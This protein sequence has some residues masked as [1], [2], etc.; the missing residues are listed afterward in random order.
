MMMAID[1]RFV[2]G[3]ELAET[4]RWV[5][6]FY[7][8]KASGEF[9]INDRQLRYFAKVVE[10][11]NMTKAAAALN[12]AQPALGLQIRQ[13]EESLGV[14]LLDRHSRGVEVTH[15]GRQLYE[16]ACN[17]LRLMEETRLEL[18][19]FGKVGRE[20]LVLGV[21]P[22]I[23][24]LVGPQFLAL[25]RSIMPN[26]SVSLVEEPSF[27]LAEGLSRDEIDL[28][29]AYDVTDR[30]G[31]STS[32]LAIEELL[33][34]CHPDAAPGHPVISLES[35]ISF[36]LV[37][38]HQRDPIRQTVE[39]AAALHNLPVRVMFEMQS[40]QATVDLVRTGQ[41]ATIVP[42][43]TVAN[44]VRRGELASR[45]I[46]NRALERH[47]QL[48]RPVRRGRFGNEQAI[49]NFIDAVLEELKRELGTL[50]RPAAG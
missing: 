47:L 41:A 24:R 43:G 37:L 18:R 6:V 38:V 3:H 45:R 1:A 23:M 22:S 11:G 36:D 8:R 10:S 26:V 9:P 17:I 31:V 32:T 44:E 5:I 40:L 48:A 14:A 33:F 20:T 7:P 42:F 25:A 29:L 49:L 34:V 27:L 15:A 21:A 35:A 12:I 39:Q 46:E 4:A 16:R 13:L 2:L 19:N 50:T 28:A 30:A